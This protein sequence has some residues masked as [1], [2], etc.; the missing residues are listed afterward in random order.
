MMAKIKDTLSVT[1]DWTSTGTAVLPSVARSSLEL[2][3]LEAYA[4]PWTAWRTWNAVETNLP[5]AGAADD[6][7]L[8]AAAW[9]VN[10]S[11]S[12]Q[13]A[14]ANNNDAVTPYY[15]RAMIEIP[16]EYDDGKTVGFRF[17][18]GMLTTIADVS[19]I[20]DLDVYES[21]KATGISSQLVT[22]TEQSINSLTLADYEFILLSTG[23][24]S[25]DI[26]DVRVVIKIRDNTAT[27]V[28][29]GIIGY[30]ALLC[31]IRG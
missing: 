22:T 19:A 25:G 13:T 11:P 6:L 10:G 30:A 28:T 9:G 29:K 8:V 4:I 20:L 14:D 18:A 7:G 24:V 31:D 17:H 15:A 1:G 5:A 12:L 27:G 2:E 3:P 21:N 26:L 16:A 23:L